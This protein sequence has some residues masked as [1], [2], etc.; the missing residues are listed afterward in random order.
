M[1]APA[2]VGVDNGGT[3]IRMIGLDAR[4]HRV[5]SLKKRS[6]SVPNLPAFLRKHLKRFSGH[7]AGLAVGSRG[8]WKKAA[9]RSVK[10]KFHGL[11]K[12]MVVM[13]DVEAAWNAAFKTHGIVVIAGTGSIAYGRSSSG[14]SA[15]AGG[16]GPEKSDEGSGYWIGEEWLRRTMRLRKFNRTRVRAIAA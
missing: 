8:V 9:R 6:P 13:S 10:R 4:G 12:Y 15:R 5:W 1:N 7:L 2:V 14:R 11:A 3:W 16:L